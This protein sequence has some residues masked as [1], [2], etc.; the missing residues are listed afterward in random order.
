[1]AIEKTMVSAPADVVQLFWVPALTIS[2]F[3]SEV[4]IQCE[5]GYEA[6]AIFDWLVGIGKDFRPMEAVDGRSVS[7]TPGPW[8]I[9]AKTVFEG[10]ERA[11]DVTA[12]GN[13]VV[14]ASDCTEGDARLI[15]AAKDLL[16]ACELALEACRRNLEWAAYK[17]E[18][19]LAA[20]NK[21]QEAISKAKE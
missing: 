7:P 4:T 21:C 5:S 14:V 8:E 9:Y 3:D 16:E 17:D 19:L 6:N 10:N 11:Y 13:H 12:E 18:S 2:K 15:A 1:M 20:A